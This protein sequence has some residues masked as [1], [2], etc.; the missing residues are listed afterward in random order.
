VLKITR[1]SAL[2]EKVL[3]QGLEQGAARD[4]EQGLEIIGEFDLD[5]PALRK[6]VVARITDCDDGVRAAAMALRDAR[7]W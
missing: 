6:A 2:D 7:G 1:L 3:L 5:T 4:R